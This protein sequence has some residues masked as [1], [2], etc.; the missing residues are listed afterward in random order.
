MEIINTDFKSNEAGEEGGSIYYDCQPS[1]T[2]WKAATSKK[3]VPCE[4]VMTSNQFEN[5][6]ASTGGAL[7]WNLIEP[8]ITPEKG[9]D[10]KYSQTLNGENKYGSLT[11][12]NNVANSYG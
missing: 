3:K 10:L 1:E 12:L 8:I 11:F 9:E 2:D 6:R 7:R 4:L 5:N